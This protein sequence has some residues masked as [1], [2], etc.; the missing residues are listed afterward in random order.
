AVWLRREATHHVT[1]RKSGPPSRSPRGHH[2]GGP[3]WR[4]MTPVGLR[5]TSLKS[6][7]LVLIVAAA[8]A[9]AGAALAAQIEKPQHVM[10]LNLCTDQLILMMLPKER[11]ASVSFLSRASER[12]LLTAEAAGVPINFGALEEVFA[13]KPDLVIAGTA[14]TPTTRTFLKQAGIPLA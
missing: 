12:P 7:T 5:E 8:L 3:L 4:A 11:I 1:A 10:S 13:A 9:S 6:K 14:S 2:L